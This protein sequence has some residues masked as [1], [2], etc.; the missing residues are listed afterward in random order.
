[1]RRPRDRADTRG[2]GQAWSW[3]T[4]IVT[5][6]P[7]AARYQIG[8]SRF[9]RARGE[10]AAG[11]FRSPAVAGSLRATPTLHSIDGGESMVPLR[12]RL[13]ACVVF[14][15]VLFGLL[16]PGALAQEK[17][18]TLKVEKKTY[19]FKEADKDMEYALF[20]PGAYDKEKKW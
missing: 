8:D 6:T 12:A 1:R 14:T 16:Q 3:F 17:K 2:S 5:V 10:P 11:A 18:A 13:S 15:G 19:A 4:S 9:V 7:P 20:V